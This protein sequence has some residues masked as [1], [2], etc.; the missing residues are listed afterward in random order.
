MECVGLTNK[1]RAVAHFI[2]REE[3]SYRNATRVV[4]DLS[5]EWFQTTLATRATKL[6]FICCESS[7]GHILMRDTWP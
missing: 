7:E 4:T 6:E 1:G 2:S 5:G 3:V